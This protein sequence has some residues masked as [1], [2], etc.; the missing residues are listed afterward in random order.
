MFYLKVF[1]MLK[2]I[3]S[4]TL[5]EIIK[6][7]ESFGLKKY[8][9]E[10]VFRWISKNIK[11]FDEMSDL[12]KDLRLFLSDKYEI[13][14]IKL[15]K[16]VTSTDGTVKFA[17]SFQ[18]GAIV[19]SVLMKYKFGYSV[20]VS[21]QVGCKMHCKFC[22]NSISIFSRNLSTSEIISQVQE[23]S[24]IENVNISNITLMGVG[25]PFDNYD[26]VIKFIKIASSQKGMNFGMRRI[27]VS[28]CGICDKIIK[29]ADERIS[30]TLS[31]SLHSVD[32]HVRSNI[33]PINRAFNLN[34]LKEACKYYNDISNKRISFEY[35]MIKGINDSKQDAKNLSS[36]L[37]GLISHVNL[38]PANNISYNGLSSTSIEKIHIFA[39]WLMSFGVNVTIR[40]TLGSDIN[41]SC[42]QLR[43]KI[44]NK[45]G[46]W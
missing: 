4:M 39:N 11:S 45:K 44:L 28:T 2:D 10:Q 18:D 41:A 8:K 40:R 7:F 14:D 22:A 46:V 31:V 34:K 16:K 9:A 29:F 36:F 42:G 37:K 30:A 25:E 23:I 19:E 38:I 1:D 6:D 43:S 20:C 35:I 24:S 21:T 5:D 12:S 32:N 3:K 15:I 33:M 26:N 17:F 13:I 27:S